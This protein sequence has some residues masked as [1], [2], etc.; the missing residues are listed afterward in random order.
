VHNHAVAGAATRLDEFFLR[1]VLRPLDAQV[2]EFMS[3]EAGKVSDKTVAVIWI[4]A[5]NYLRTLD[6]KPDEVRADI[7]AAATTLLKGPIQRLLIGSMPS[8]AGLLKAPNKVDPVPVEKYHEI[9]HVH[10]RNMHAVID[11]LQQEF[12]AK[13]IALYDAYEIN[14]ATIDR[15]ADF[16]FSS[17]TDGCYK[18]NYLGDYEGEPGFCSDYLGWKFWDYTHPNSRMHCYYAA[19]FLQSLHEAGWL[20]QVDAEKAIDRCR[21][22]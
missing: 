10:N 16:G 8:L 1:W 13:S 11:E 6:M 17:L 4:G 21:H 2:E 5:N 7:K 12:P 20:E 14:Q 22:F 15:P 18:G 3:E 9:T 19:R